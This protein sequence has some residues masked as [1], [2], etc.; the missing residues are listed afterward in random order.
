[1]NLSQV[2]FKNIIIHIQFVLFITSVC[3]I[4]TERVII[5]I[6]ESVSLEV[7]SQ[8]L[9]L[10]IASAYIDITAIKISQHRTLSLSG[11]NN[12]L[13]QRSATS[14]NYYETNLSSHVVWILLFIFF[15]FTVCR[16]FGYVV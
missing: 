7:F 3:S 16:Y 9:S 2:R 1:M 4:L 12:I 6:E 11:G 8:L 14:K 13:Y 5:G 15:Y 10:E